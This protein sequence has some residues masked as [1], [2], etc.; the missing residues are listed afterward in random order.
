MSRATD[1]ILEKDFIKKVELAVKPGS[2]MDSHSSRM[3]VTGHLK[4]PTQIQH[5]SCLRISIWSCSERGLP[6]HLC[7]HRCGALLPHHFNLTGP[8]GL[9]RYIFCGTFHRF[10]PST[11]YLALYPAEPRLSSAD[12]QNHLQR[13]PGQ[14]VMNFNTST[15]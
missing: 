6:C 13:L 3:P 7:C 5:G 2:V 1:A 10:T 12:S 15:G 14:L 8:E 9:R 11:R 4:Q